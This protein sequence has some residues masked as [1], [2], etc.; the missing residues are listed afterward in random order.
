MHQVARAI[1]GIV[2]T[3]FTVGGN[4]Y[5][6]SCSPGASALSEALHSARPARDTVNGRPVAEQQPGSL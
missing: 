4:E 2:P 5:V 6:C 1:N 3:G